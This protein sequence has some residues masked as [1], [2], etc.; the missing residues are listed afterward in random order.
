MRPEVF[1]AVGLV[2]GGLVGVLT[3]N[4]PLW[5]GAGLALGAGM[6]GLVRR[7]QAQK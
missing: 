1:V 2:F 4:I 5:G 7:R 6:A 3:G